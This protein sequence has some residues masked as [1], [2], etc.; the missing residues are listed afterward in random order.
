MPRR[1]GNKTGFTGT[2]RNARAAIGP[3]RTSVADRESGSYPTQRQQ[4]ASKERAA[5]QRKLLPCQALKHERPTPRPTQGTRKPTLEPTKRPTR[6]PTNAPVAFKEPT[7]RPTRKPTPIPTRNP[8]PTRQPTQGPQIRDLAA[9]RVGPA[10]RIQA[11]VVVV[12]AR[13]RLMLLFKPRN[14]SC[15]SYES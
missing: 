15:K 3:K 8:E 4:A 12:T 11:W 14:T 10:P 5:R 6:K 2:P 13:R 7:R 1:P 9:F